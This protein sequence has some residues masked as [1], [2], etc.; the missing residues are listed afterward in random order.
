MLAAAMMSVA[1]LAAGSS[2]PVL[3]GFDV[4]DYFSLNAAS[5]GTVRNIRWA[6]HS[7][8]TLCH[9]IVFPLPSPSVVPLTP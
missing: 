6:A 3:Y 9:A 8:L 5:K 1:A 4:V 7:P 2:K